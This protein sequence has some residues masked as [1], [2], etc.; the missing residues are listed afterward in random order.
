MGESDRLG[1][2]WGETVQVSC[3]FM[4]Q[5]IGTRPI[6]KTRHPV[7]RDAEQYQ[8]IKILNRV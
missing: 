5:A 4:M 3:F 7:M 6:E 2:G 1:N 8:W